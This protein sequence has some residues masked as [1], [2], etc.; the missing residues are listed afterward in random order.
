MTRQEELNSMLNGIASDLTGFIGASVVDM[1]TGMSLAAVSNRADFDLEVASAYNSEMVKAKLKTMRAL[2][3]KTGL[4]DMLITLD[5]QFHL[6]RLLSQD[7]FVYAA[8]SSQDTNLAILR[9]VVNQHL[10]KI[11]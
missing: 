5:D 6:I 10:N 11:S 7:Q 3:I 2:N 4:Q 1:T 9:S 8:V